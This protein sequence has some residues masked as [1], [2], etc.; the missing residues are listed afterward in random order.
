MAFLYS[1]SIKA[2]LY[3]KPIQFQKAD[4]YDVNSTELP[5]NVNILNQLCDR[6]Q[7][8]NTTT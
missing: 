7:F 2:T 5:S 8:I 3:Q 4:L 1:V 6:M